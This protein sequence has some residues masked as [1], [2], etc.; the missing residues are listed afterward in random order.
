MTSVVV[1]AA[2]AAEAATLI[3]LGVIVKAASCLSSATAEATIVLS[4]SPNPRLLLDFKQLVEE[5][6]GGTLDL[7]GRGGGIFCGRGC[8]PCLA[9]LATGE[10]E[11]AESASASMAAGSASMASEAEAVARLSG[12]EKTLK[13]LA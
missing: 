2:V 7:G 11:V 4:L 8:S 1:E 3:G 12:Q 13:Y 9:L 6:G 10:H 5:S